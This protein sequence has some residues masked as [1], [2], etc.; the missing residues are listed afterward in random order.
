[1]AT[2]GVGRHR[3]EH[4]AGRPLRAPCSCCLSVFAAI[5]VFFA[6]GGL[7]LAAEP[8]DDKWRVDVGPYV[9][10]TSISGDM[11]LVGFT[12]PIDAKFSEIVPS[13]DFVLG[14]GFAF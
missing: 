8:G 6:A 9:G 11:T 7:T 12:T 13:V 4:F 2:Q 3:Y 5:F 1:M 14:V 10:L